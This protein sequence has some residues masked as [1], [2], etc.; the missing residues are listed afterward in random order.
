M[1]FCQV[2]SIEPVVFLQ[3][4]HHDIWHVRLDRAGQG[5]CSNQGFCN[6]SHFGILCFVTITVCMAWWQIA[7]QSLPYEPYEAELLPVE[8][9]CSRIGSLRSAHVTTTNSFTCNSTSSAC[10]SAS[11]LSASRKLRQ[12]VTGCSA[13]TAVQSLLV[14]FQSI[15]CTF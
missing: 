2:L 11:M 1:L 7:A 6:M 10:D 14:H 4:V 3:H 8:P 15:A 12:H 9:S 5:F 13:I